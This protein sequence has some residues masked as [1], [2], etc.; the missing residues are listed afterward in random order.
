MHAATMVLNSSIATNS[1][2]NLRPSDEASRGRVLVVVREPLGGIRTYLLYN[3]RQLVCHGYEFTIIAPKSKPFELFKRDFEDCS[4]VDFRETPASSRQLIRTIAGEL[5]SGNY[6][7]VHSQGLRSGFN[8][9]VANLI[10]QVPHILTLH[11]VIVPLNDIPGRLKW[12]KKRLIGRVTSRIDVI[13]PVS[14]DCRDNHLEHFPEWQQGKCCV[15]VITNGID[16][17]RVVGGAASHT[18]KNSLREQF[19]IP[20]DA[21]LIG[22]FGRLTLQKGFPVLL[23]AMRL[24]ARDNQYGKIHLAAV[25]DRASYGYKESWWDIVAHDELLAPVVH[26]IDPV[27][28]V[29]PLLAQVDVLAMPSLWEA[30]GLLAAEAMVLGIPVVGTDAIGLREVLMGTPALISSAGD[31]S[32]LAAGILAASSPEIQEQ[33]KEH[34]QFARIRFQ[35]DPSA[36]LLLKTYK[37]LAG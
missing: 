22:F 16:I 4:Q 14:H 17:D 25:L 6:D 8:T 24:L 30:Y 35:N 34:A 27:A 5:R 21:T 3:L 18:N 20:C 15:Q 23:D 19:G 1:T 7:L 28:E 11:D 36:N 32:E 26:F 13:I 10:S 12:L 2:I 31:S 37:C 29:A 33:F 9:A